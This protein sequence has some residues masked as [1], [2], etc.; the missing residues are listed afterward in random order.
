MPFVKTLI[1]LEGH[2]GHEYLPETRKMMPN[3]HTG[4][5]KGAL[6]LLKAGE[7]FVLFDTNRVKLYRC[8][9]VEKAL[10]EQAALGSSDYAQAVADF[11]QER[12][13]R[14]L[15][16]LGRLSGLSES[17]ARCSAYAGSLGDRLSQLWLHVC[18]HCNLRCRYCYAQD[19]SY[20]QGSSFM[21]EET[22]RQGI[23]LLLQTAEPHDHLTI[24]FGGGEPLLNFPTI[25]S[26]V[27]HAVHRQQSSGVHFSFRILTNGTI[28]TERILEFLS[29]HQ[30]SLQISIDGPREIH[31]SN[32]R[33]REGKGS[34]ELIEGTLRLLQ[35]QDFKSFSIRST[36]CHQHCDPANVVPFLEKKGIREIALRPVMTD[37]RNSLRLSD[38]DIRAI[39]DYYDQVKHETVGDLRNDPC[40]PV[41]EAFA[42]YLQ[43][44]QL[45]LKAKRHCGAGRSMLVLTPQG[46]LYPCPSLVGKAGFRA[47]TLAEGLNQDA[48]APFRNLN[49]D[50]KPVCKECWARNL[51]GGGCVSL[52]YDINGDLLL[53]DP[54]EC[55]LSKARIL[56]AIDIYAQMSDL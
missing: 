53:P 18:H 51:C 13:L 29:K 16:R 12:V 33:T 14:G 19:G 17:L 28:M 34:F 47:G 2:R 31:D 41:P 1:V 52:A 30:V 48:L 36:L 32:R 24:I 6:H 42:P 8:S 3:M 50:T 46:E 27:S 23:D 38:E 55:S 26:A 9:E 49:V 45:G 22:A 39:T 11:G 37:P 44:L 40:S 15:Q 7:G 21:S 35:S 54:V 25:K 56:G 43:K 10:L 20:G 4:I 5:D